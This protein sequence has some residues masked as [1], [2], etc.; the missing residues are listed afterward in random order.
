MMNSVCS[1]REKLRRTD[2]LNLVYLHRN[3]LNSTVKTLTSYIAIST[4]DYI[5][6]VEGCHKN[7]NRFYTSQ[8]KHIFVRTGLPTS[9]SSGLTKSKMAN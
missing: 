6:E 4:I 1:C 2:V 7:Y 8:Y 3:V 9:T 5:T